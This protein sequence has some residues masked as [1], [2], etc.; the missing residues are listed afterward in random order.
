MSSGSIT[1][2]NNVKL[3][4]KYFLITAFFLAFPFPARAAAY[5]VSNSGSDS[6]LGTHSSPF[7]TIRKG[8]SGLNPGDFLYVQGGTYLQ[9]DQLDISRS[10]TADAPITVMTDP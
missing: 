2:I 5:Y 1:I 8:V 3:S 9:L 4:L 6:N 10:G 7:K